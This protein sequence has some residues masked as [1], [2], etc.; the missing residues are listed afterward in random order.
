MNCQIKKYMN[1]KL[2]EDVAKIIDNKFLDLNFIQMLSIKDLSRSINHQLWNENKR[3]FPVHKRK[4]I[5]VFYELSNH[6]RLDSMEWIKL[7]I[8]WGDRIPFLKY[9]FE[10]SHIFFDMKKIYTH[11]NIGDEI[12]S[13]KNDDLI[14]TRRIT[15][16]C[17][18]YYFKTSYSMNKIELRGKL[19]VYLGR[20]EDN[21][22]YKLK[23]YKYCKNQPKPVNLSRGNKRA[24]FMCKRSPDFHDWPERCQICI[25]IPEF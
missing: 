16:Y 3:W 15:N 10:E 5:L 6:I 7:R 25:K 12:L 17:K 20:R 1:K 2:N 23:S 9:S 22:K 24:E 4:M 13:R 14:D 21:E 8:N 19:I 18:H 11:P